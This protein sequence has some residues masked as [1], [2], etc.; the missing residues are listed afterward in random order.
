M[1]NRPRLKQRP[2]LRQGEPVSSSPTG[3]ITIP[4]GLLWHNEDTKPRIILAC[5]YLEI[6]RIP[7]LVEELKTCKEQWDKTVFTKFKRLLKI[8]RQAFS[9]GETVQR[10]AKQMTGDMIDQCGFDDEAASKDIEN[11]LGGWV[12]K[13]TCGSEAMA[14]CIHYLWL[15]ETAAM[16]QYNKQRRFYN[17][18][19]K[20]AQQPDSAFR[21]NMERMAEG[22][23]GEQAKYW[24]VIMS[25]ELKRCDRAARRE[26]KR[27]VREQGFN[28]MYE[29]NFMRAVWCFVQYECLGKRVE[30]IAIEAE[31]RNITLP[32]KTLYDD[33]NRDK[34]F[35]PFYDAL[36]LYG[37]ITKRPRDSV[38]I[39]YMAEANPEKSQNLASQVRLNLP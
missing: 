11:A 39:D 5:L 22:I 38:K 3:E 2:I 9:L 29:T 18:A 14:K 7:Q 28:L 27:G 19:I 30:D 25:P 8:G 17:R 31:E 12:K 10:Q 37:S 33:W 34:Y 24:E 35:K 32:L 36:A 13:W 1:S 23:A 26:A 16:E 20:N 21:R 15:F 4:P 6:S